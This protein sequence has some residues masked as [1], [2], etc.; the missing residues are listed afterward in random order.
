MAGENAVT[1]SMPGYLNVVV[2]PCEPPLMAVVELGA[3]GPLVCRVDDGRSVVDAGLTLVEK[4]PSFDGKADEKG[5]GAVV[6]KRGSEVP[7]DIAGIELGVAFDAAFSEVTEADA[8]VLAA[9][10][11]GE[12]TRVDVSAL[13][14][15]LIA[16][17]EKLG[18]IETL[19]GL[20]LG[21]SN[22][23]G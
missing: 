18:V 15:S 7:F 22:V 12:T 19:T 9:V 5:A 17:T 6:S 2:F 21:L 10:T 8:V 16:V 3:A 1:V 4:R 11:E 14:I 20:A 13:S 23:P